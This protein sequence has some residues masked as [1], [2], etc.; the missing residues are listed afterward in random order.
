MRKPAAPKTEQRIADRI[1][2][3]I[4]RAIGVVA[5]TIAIKRM[6]ARGAMAVAD[7]YHGGRMDRSATRNWRPGAGSANADT[8]FD[9]TDLRARARDLARNNPTACAAVNSNV[10]SVIGTGLSMRPRIDAKAL[11]LEDDEAEEYEDLI[12][13]EWKLWAESQNCDAARTLDFY[14]LQEQAF[15]AML[16]SGDVFA[17][18]PSIQRPQTPYRLAV[19]LVEA[20]RVSNPGW[21]PDR[22]HIVGGVEFDTYGAP[23]Q[24][25]ISNKHPGD[26]YRSGMEWTAYPVFGSKTGRRNV[27]HLFEQLRP[28]QSRGVPF[29]SPVIEPLRQLGV[30]TDSELQAAVISGAFSVFIK[31]DPEAFETL[32]E[33]DTKK[34][35]IDSASRWDGSLTSGKAV[36]LLPGEEVSNANPG[37]P[38]AQ[39]DPFVAAIFKQVGMALELPYEVLTMSFQSSYS[40]ARAA[41]LTAWRVFYKRR[42]F[43]AARFCQPIY[44]EF[45]AEAVGLGRLS[46]FGFFADPIAHKAWCTA[47]WAGDGP[48][49]IDPVKDVQAAKM[50]IDESISTRDAESIRYDG[51]DFETKHRQRVKEEQ[52]RREGGLVMLAQPAGAIRPES[53]PGEDEADETD[54]GLEGDEIENEGGSGGGMDPDK[55]K[56]IAD[57]TGVAVRAGVITPQIDDEKVFRKNLGLPEM[58]SAVVDKWKRD[59]GARAPITLASQ[60]DTAAN[61]Q[62]SNASPDE[63]GQDE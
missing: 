36:N 22:D 34:S 29:L 55:A 40:A 31:M 58:S 63:A 15:R 61:R 30:Y 3:A 33:D 62:G 4:D 20:D 28:G 8:T 52:M 26:M 57:A 42:S 46:L 5:P 54:E 16:E 23:K 9:R 35:V 45:L 2:S 25:H 6:Q 11:G 39:F 18:L 38:N 10:T 41:L 12:E 27:L 59:G 44:E 17:V 37:R 53:E 43:M 48:G 51:I 32:F 47:E 19:Q 50:R 7:S 1:G 56:A 49:S 21:A 60:N 24:Y 14:G 13:R